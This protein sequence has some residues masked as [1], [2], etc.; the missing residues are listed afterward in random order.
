MKLYGGRKRAIEW[1]EAGSSTMRRRSARYARVLAEVEVAHDQEA[2]K[3]EKLV[4]AVDE[5][6]ILLELTVIEYYDPHYIEN[7]PT[8]RG[9]QSIWKARTVEVPP[10]TRWLYVLG[11]TCP[12]HGEYEIQ[13]WF[14]DGSPICGCCALAKLI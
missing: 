10:R 7:W 4:Y 11:A 1:T 9:L 12:E 5:L 2:C 3:K 8:P 13:A 14:P 6:G